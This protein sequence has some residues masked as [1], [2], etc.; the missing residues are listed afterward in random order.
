V[1]LLT[2]VMAGVVLAT[3]YSFVAGISAMAIDGEV[4][5]HTSLQWMVR[6]VAFQAVA[7]LFI[8]IALLG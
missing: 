1:D 5:H 7:V 2:L 8:L 6:R 4:G 3:V